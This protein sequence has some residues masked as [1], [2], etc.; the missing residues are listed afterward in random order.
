LILYQLYSNFNNLY[1]EAKII[2]VL[3]I[4]FG[5]GVWGRIFKF[6]I[7]ATTDFFFSAGDDL[8]LVGFHDFLA[9]AKSSVL[10]YLKHAQ[11]LT[12]S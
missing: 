11:H 8:V 10:K 9:L 7:L 2:F 5:D 12:R 1:E 6:S 3:I 4:H